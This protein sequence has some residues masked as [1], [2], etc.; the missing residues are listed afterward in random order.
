MQP[1]R[2]STSSLLNESSRRLRLWAAFVALVAA[3]LLFNAITPSADSMQMLPR[4][5]F[6]VFLLALACEFLDSSLGM[7][8][9]TTLTPLLLLSGFA[10]LDIVP[11][12]LL[13]EALTGAAA[14]YMHQRDGNVN[15]V[16][17]RHARRTALLLIAL[18]T[19]G[20]IAAAALN[21]PR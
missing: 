17:D 16:H 3:L 21:S 8:Y 10:P 19:L 18:S 4:A 7:G 2:A 6:L 14:G 9:G 5:A 15:F 11:A 20:A 1:L 12:V 13:S